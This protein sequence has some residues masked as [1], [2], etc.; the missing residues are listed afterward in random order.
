M[1]IPLYKKWQ[2]F[3]R[4]CY[5][6]L[7]WEGQFPVALNT[8]ATTGSTDTTPNLSKAQTSVL[9]PEPFW[10]ETLLIS[11]SSN[12]GGWKIFILC[13]TKT[14]YR[15]VCSRNILPSVHICYIWHYLGVPWH[16]G[17]ISVSSG[18]STIKLPDY[19]LMAER[20][21]SLSEG[22]KWRYTTVVTHTHCGSPM[23]SMIFLHPLLEP[24]N[25]WLDWN[26]WLRTK[27]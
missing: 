15:K 22:L 16:I 21:H 4:L 26:C 19:L 5:I 10:L 23:C 20:V 27:E 2:A 3:N 17:A 6:L 24:A 13:P 8:Q 25:T 12:H 18:Q 14:E 1:G 11:I 7:T 9:E